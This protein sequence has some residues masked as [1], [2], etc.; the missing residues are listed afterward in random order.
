MFAI[1]NMDVR[2][3]FME[4]VTF[5]QGL[6]KGEGMSHVGLSAKANVCCQLLS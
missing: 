6:G 1:L 3:G 2:E 4:V 5:E